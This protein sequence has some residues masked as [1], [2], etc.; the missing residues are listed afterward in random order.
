MRVREYPRLPQ[1]TP[2]HCTAPGRLT[3]AW[4]WVYSHSSPVL[5]AAAIPQTTAA[6]S[7]LAQ[8]PRSPAK[9]LGLDLADSAETLDY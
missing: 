2:P 4:G 6:V 8:R 1:I 3:W 7:R 9:R 5:L